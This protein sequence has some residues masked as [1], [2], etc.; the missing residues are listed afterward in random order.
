VYFRKSIFEKLFNIAEYTNL[1]KE[2]KAM[3]DSS[4]KYKWDN[5]NRLDYAVEEAVK[6][7]VKEAVASTEKQVTEKERL[8]ARE[9]MLS[10]GRE[11]KKEGLSAKFIAKTTKLSIEDIEKL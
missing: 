9:D 4:L 6:E 5:Q 11:L 7:A 3:Y 8:K 10:V 1:T 2:E